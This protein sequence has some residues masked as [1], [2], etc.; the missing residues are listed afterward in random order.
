MQ[1]TTYDGIDYFPITQTDIPQGSPAIYVPNEMIITSTKTYNEFPSLA[2][3]ESQLTAAGLDDKLPLFRIFYK[4]IAE[5]EKGSDS[6]YYNW[7][8]SLPRTYNNGASMTYDCFDCL[9]PYAA[10]CAMADRTNLLNFQKAVRPLGGP[11]AAPFSETI[12]NDG[13]ILKWAYNIAITRSI[14]M[15]GERIIAPMVDMLNHSSEPNC[16]ITYDGQDC[17]AIALVDIPAGSPLSITYGDAND[18]T[19]LFANYGF[20]TEDSPGTF[21]KVMHM[22][23][24]IEEMGYSFS[25]LLFYKDGNISPAVFDVVLYHVL[26][27]NNE[28]EAQTYYQ[29]VMNGDEATKQQ[30]QNQYWSYTKEELQNHVDKLLEDIDKWSS[31]A[32][33]MDLNTHPRA[34][35]IIQ[36]NEFVK[37]IFLAVKPNLDNM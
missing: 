22:V 4:I 10:Y 23:K 33:Q 21:C 26:K 18:S 20:L 3:V 28:G 29:A 16:Q 17:Y 34:P 24:E 35:L 7:L 8:N 13:D 1:L 27:K 25:D 5:Y 37:N 14:D 32:S 9:P 31:T 2:T 11:S 6:Y 36:H 12:L 30:Y 19:P 15:N